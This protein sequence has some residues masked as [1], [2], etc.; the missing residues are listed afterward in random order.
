[1]VSRTN[2]ELIFAL[3]LPVT[4]WLRVIF[5]QISSHTFLLEARVVLQMCIGVVSRPDTTH[6][7][8]VG[9]G[10][11]IRGVINIFKITSM[12]RCPLAIPAIT[13]GQQAIENSHRGIIMRKFA[14]FLT[15]LLFA[16]LVVIAVNSNLFFLASAQDG[17]RPHSL[18]TASVADV[19][20]AALDYTQ[21]RFRVV[22]TPKILL[23]R[24]IA[25]EEL[26][27]LGLS[28]IGFGGKVPPLAL[29][30]LEGK[31]EVQIRGMDTPEQA[32]YL[33]YVFDLNTGAPTL[34]EGSRQGI[35]YEDLILYAKTFTPLAGDQPIDPNAKYFDPGPIQFAPPVPT[36]K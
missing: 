11:G 4:Q 10:T 26:P 30:I 6:T 3:L 1:M 25:K 7:K 32:K 31:F 18:L 34:I 5:V 29:V 36:P 20:K 9:M 17:F 22:G 16:T 14:L 33:F 12:E 27:K 24:S 21:S 28:E 13:A 15:A 35:D 8:T 23:T 19:Q 2:G